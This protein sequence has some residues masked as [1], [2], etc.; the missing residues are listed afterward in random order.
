MKNM[1]ETIYILKIE[2]YKDKYKRLFG[3]ILIT[4]AYN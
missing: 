4:L 3:N 1:R 2:I